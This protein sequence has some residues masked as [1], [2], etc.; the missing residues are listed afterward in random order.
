M[1]T[2][3]ASLKKT[4]FDENP[5]RAAVEAQIAGVKRSLE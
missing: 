5:R 3:F 4:G 2:D 1:K